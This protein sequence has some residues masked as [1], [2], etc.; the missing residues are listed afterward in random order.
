VLAWRLTR[1]GHIHDP[2][3][4][5]GAARAGSRWNSPGVRMGY[6]SSSRPLAVLEMLVHVSRNTVP[7]D[8]VFIP[9]DVPDELIH[10]AAIA[11]GWN[12]LPE[13]AVAR[14]LGDRWI[15]RGASVAMLVPSIILPAERNVLINPAHPDFGRVRILPVESFTFDR[16]LLL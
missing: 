6:T 12:S 4:G 9:I 2:L 1:R 7:L 15:E 13:S 8:P 3:S 10:E 5:A 14:H 11:S 16:R